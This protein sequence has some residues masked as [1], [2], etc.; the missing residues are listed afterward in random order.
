MSLDKPAFKMKNTIC[1][2]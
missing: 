1:Q 2:K